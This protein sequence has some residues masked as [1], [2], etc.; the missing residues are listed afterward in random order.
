MPKDRMAL[1]VNPSDDSTLFVAGN[2]G[3]LAWRVAWKTGTWTEA[4][5]KDTSDDSAP[6][7][8]RTRDSNSRLSLSLPLFPLVLL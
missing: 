6:H 5:G 4:H 3:A 1:L 8:V 2:A 7:G